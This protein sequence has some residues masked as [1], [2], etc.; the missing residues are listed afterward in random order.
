MS[1]GKMKSMLQLEQRKNSSL[2][3]HLLKL[4]DNQLKSYVK[5]DIL[6]RNVIFYYN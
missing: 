5:F 3:L 2:H 1:L 6:K 4:D